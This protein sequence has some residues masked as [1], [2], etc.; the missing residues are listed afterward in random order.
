MATF[1]VGDWVIISPN[2]PRNISRQSWADIGGKKTQILDHDHHDDDYKVKI[3]VDGESR[4]RV[5]WITSDFLIKTNPPTKIVFNE[6]IE[7][8]N[9][10]I[11]HQNKLRDDIFK[12]IFASPKPKESSVEKTKKPAPRKEQQ[13]Q[14]DF[15][16][17][18]ENDYYSDYY[19]GDDY[20]DPDW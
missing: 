3:L 12:Q 14:E 18:S 20:S 17:E 15:E 1:R 11:K 6:Q 19:Y 5:L 13:R 4:P 9:R 8:Y 7:E 16:Q 10:Q 2:P